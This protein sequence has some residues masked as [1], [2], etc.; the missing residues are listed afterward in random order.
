[1]RVRF[2]VEEWR[3]GFGVGESSLQGFGFLLL[4]PKYK[5]WS[6]SPFPI[7]L[8]MKIQG[9]YS[10]SNIGKILHYFKSI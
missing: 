7:V 4:S 6:N 3:L 5:H 10:S 8:G 2:D 9:S 1:M